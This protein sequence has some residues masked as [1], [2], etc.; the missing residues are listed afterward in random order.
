MKEHYPGCEYM[1][2]MNQS[3][4]GTRCEGKPIFARDPAEVR[5][6]L[7]LAIKIVSVMIIGIV[8]SF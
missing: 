7:S 4:N 2:R 1:L 6:H 5:F 3:M 8:K